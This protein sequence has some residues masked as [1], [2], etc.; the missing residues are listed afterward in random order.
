MAASKEPTTTSMRMCTPKRGAHSPGADS[1]LTAQQ[2][3]G[4]RKKAYAHL[5]RSS[6]HLSRT[7]SGGSMRGVKRK[8]FQSP[9]VALATS[10]RPVALAELTAPRLTPLALRGN[11]SNKRW[12]EDA[13]LTSPMVPARVVLAGIDN[14]SHTPG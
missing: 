13:G 8:P 1:G 14:I 9:V 7:P 6:P 3:L 12:R 2:S 5:A 10:G 11:K 4:S